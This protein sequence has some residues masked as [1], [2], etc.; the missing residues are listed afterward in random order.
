MQTTTLPIQV[1]GNAPQRTSAPANADGG[2]E[3][4]AALSRELEQRHETT[5]PAPAP[6][7]STARQPQADQDGAATAAAAPEPAKPADA[8]PETRAAGSADDSQ[9]KQDTDSG[10][11]EQNPAAAAVTDMLALVASMQQPL[12]KNDAAAEANAAIAPPAADGAEL[13][14]L[15]APAKGLG[16]DSAEPAAA[17]AFAVLGQ[18]RNPAAA[19]PGAALAPAGQAPEPR[20]GHDIFAAQLKAQQP[21][22]LPVREALADAAAPKEPAPAPQLVAQAPATPFEIAQPVAMPADRIGARVGSA[23]WDQQ[24]GQKIVWMVAGGEQSASLTLNPPDLGPLQVVLSVSND[25]ASVAFSANQLEVRQALEN[26]L[27][28][29]REMMNES[30]IAL[31]NATVDAG[32]QGGRQAPGG[33]QPRAG[34]GGRLDSGSAMA[35]NAPRSATRVTAL[36]ERGMVDTFA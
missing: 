6:K 32:S 16:K 36:G 29:L 19:T 11:A 15:Q 25:Q 27:P 8:K 1:T 12:Q 17:R 10:A 20:A 21:D 24:V 22:R 35:D 7:P 5:P 9:A 3:F 33:D 28:R 26:A 30:G 23:G 13:P 18:V 31:G 14:T 4:R 34:G 2:A